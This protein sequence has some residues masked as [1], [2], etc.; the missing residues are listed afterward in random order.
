MMMKKAIPPIIM[1]KRS[2]PKTITG[3][4]ELLTPAAATPYDPRSPW[5]IRVMCLSSSES[6]SN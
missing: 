4:N 6:S 5:R 3:K 2:S 1:R